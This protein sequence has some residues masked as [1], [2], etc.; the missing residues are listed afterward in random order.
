[1]KLAKEKKTARILRD[2]NS[3]N[4]MDRFKSRRRFG[5]KMPGELFHSF[6]DVFVRF[7]MLKLY[8]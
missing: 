5:M 7:L 4:A 2:P 3:H 1:M 8:I 6:V